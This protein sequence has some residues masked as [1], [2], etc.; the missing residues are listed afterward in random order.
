MKWWSLLKSIPQISEAS[1]AVVTTKNWASSASIWYQVI[2]VGVTLATAFGVSVA[3]SAEDIQT[4]SV[5][6]A[7]AVPAVCT[8]VDAIAAIWLRLRTSQP[9]QGTKVAIQMAVTD[10]TGQ[11]QPPT[12]QPQAN[13]QC[14]G[15]G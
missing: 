3:M 12:T 2:K 4:I 9:I 14:P 1:T 7:V 13:D 11:N 10:Q 5:G 6:L 15:D 8:L